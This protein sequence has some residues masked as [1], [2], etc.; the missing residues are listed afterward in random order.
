[1]LEVTLLA[2]STPLTC[3]Q[4]AEMAGST[5]SFGTATVDA[6]NQMIAANAS[7][8]ATATGGSGAN[9]YA[10]VEA[11]G[12]VTG[13]TYFQGSTSGVI[14]RTMP[15]RPP[16]LTITSRTVRRSTSTR[17]PYRTGSA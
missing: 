12:A 1:M 4:A 9:I 15:I 7:G 5:I 2:E 6:V 10:Y 13:S 8:T 16:F 3:L 14:P 11:V 17:F